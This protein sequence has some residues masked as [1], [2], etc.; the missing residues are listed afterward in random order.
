MQCSA[1]QCVPLP[2]PLT[3][4]FAHMC[5]LCCQLACVSLRPHFV[6]CLWRMRAH[7]HTHT[8][9]HKSLLRQWLCLKTRYVW[10]CRLSFCIMFRDRPTISPWVLVLLPPCL[11]AVFGG[12][13]LPAALLSLTLSLLRCCPRMLAVC[14]GLVRWEWWAGVWVGGGGVGVGGGLGLL[15]QHPACPCPRCPPT[16]SPP[17]PTPP[18]P[19]LSTPCLA[20]VVRGA[21]GLGV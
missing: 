3:P 10:V 7:T 4:S 15:S 11:E 5:I 12:I 8:L 16:H 17:S 19:V 18:H 6:P 13:P 20:P 1:V 21:V 2:L 9:T 14:L